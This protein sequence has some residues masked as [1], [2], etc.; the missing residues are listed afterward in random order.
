[1]FVFA[2]R[3]SSFFKLSLLGLLWPPALLICFDVIL[4][5]AF[6]DC[7]VYALCPLEYG[8]SLGCSETACACGAGPDLGLWSPKTV[9]AVIFETLKYLEPSPALDRKAAPVTE[10]GVSFER[11]LLAKPL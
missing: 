9:Y 6:S 8:C 7:Y 10:L 5:V 11:G 1:M 2:L 3:F 4:W